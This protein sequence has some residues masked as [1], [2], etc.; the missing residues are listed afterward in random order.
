MVDARAKVTGSAA[1][2]EDLMPE[3]YLTAMVLHSTVAHANV[4]K[5][6]IS[7]ALE[8]KGV[9]DIVTCFDVPDLPFPT[10]GHPW[11]TEKKHQ[12]YRRPPVAEQACAL[13]RR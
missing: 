5:I 10:A 11:S 2:A 4:V 3:K 7:K 13:L 1:Y 6:D 8:V 12:E 9:V